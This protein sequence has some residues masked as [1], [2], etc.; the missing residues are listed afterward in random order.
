MFIAPINYLHLIPASQKQHLLLAHL[1]TNKDY[2]RFYQKRQ[3]RGDFIIIDNS[4][5]E[6]KK[7]L[8]PKEYN[9][10]V[11]QSGITPDII[12]APDYPNEPYQKTI[13]ASSKFSEDYGNFFDVERTK[14]MIVPQSVKGDVGGWL[15]AYVTLTQLPNVTYVGMSI[16]GIPNAFCSLTKT[17]DISYNRI[18]ATVY[19][20]NNQ[21]VAPHVKHH[22]LGLG[23]DI[24]ELQI[25]RMLGV[26][27]SNDSSSAFW[28]GIVGGQHGNGGC[29][30]DSSATGQKTGKIHTP[31]DFDYPFENNKDYY[32]KQNIRFIQEMLT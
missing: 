19:L 28:R 25:Q 18:F 12:V 29:L 23:N 3:E 20:K 22:Y 9:E 30:Y 7:P 16:L 6:F 13:E 15:Q 32:I 8:E 27:D 1:L 31:V 21:C 4:A 5:F 11:L 2:C 24:R 17:S 10:L 14:L 26:A